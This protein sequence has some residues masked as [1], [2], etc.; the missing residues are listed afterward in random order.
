MQLWKIVQNIS[1]QEEEYCDLFSFFS[2]SCCMSY[3]YLFIHF[4]QNIF[5]QVFL[6]NMFQK[7]PFFTDFIG[8]VLAYLQKSV[9]SDMEILNYI[10]IF[11]HEW[12]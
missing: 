6:A 7:F 1:I 11:V 12:C 3:F 10:N 2:C 5:Q 9:Y 8:Q 4:N